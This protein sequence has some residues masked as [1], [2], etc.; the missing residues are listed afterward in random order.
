MRAEGAFDEEADDVGRFLRFLPGNDGENARL[1][2]EIERGDAEN[3]KKNRARDIAL[4]IFHFAAEVADVVVAEIAVDR[5]YGGVAEAGE[6]NPGET[7]GA[8]GVGEDEAFVEVRCAAV[9]EPGD[10]GDHD[11]PENRGDFSDGGDATIEEHDSDRD[12]RIAT[13]RL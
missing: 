2:R 7:P 12:R 5:L 1:H 8:G 4:G 11:D 13:R 6:E 10:R 3:R 9:D